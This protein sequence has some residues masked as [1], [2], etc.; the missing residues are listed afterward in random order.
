MSKSSQL[1]YEKMSFSYSFFELDI[2]Q[3][4]IQQVCYIDWLVFEVNFSY[5]CCKVSTIIFY[6]IQD[7]GSISIFVMRAKSIIIQL[8][9]LSFDF[10]API[11]SWVGMVVLS[12]H[13]RDICYGMSI[14]LRLKSSIGAKWKLFPCNQT[15]SSRLNLAICVYIEVNKILFSDIVH[16]CIS[17]WYYRNYINPILQITINKFETPTYLPIF[18][19]HSL[20]DV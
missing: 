1:W 8:F 7:G 17:H 4:S 6:I 3:T 10:C 5:F 16:C 2:T 14:S 11:E 15:V 9:K 18:L 20:W 13:A 19:Y 12:P